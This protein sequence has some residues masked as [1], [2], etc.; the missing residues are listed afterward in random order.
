LVNEDIA[1]RYWAK[2]HAPDN[3]AT[4]KAEIYFGISEISLF[5]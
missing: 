4:T 1:T 3:P 5:A 2:E